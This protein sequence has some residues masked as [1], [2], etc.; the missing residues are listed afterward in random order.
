MNQRKHNRGAAIITIVMFF[1]IISV[2]VALGL[3]SPT[4]REYTSAR[5]FEKSK[6]AYYLSEA[7]NEDATYRIKNSKTI[8]MTETL[9]LGGNTAITTIT[10][11]GGQQDIVSVGN[12]NTHTRKVSAQLVTSSGVSFNYGVQAGA[13]GVFLGNSASITG[14]LFS[15]GPVCG[16][17]ATGATCSGGSGTNT[18]TG[19]IIS[20]GSGTNGVIGR[21]RNTTAGSAMYAGTISNSTIVGPAYCNTISGSSSSPSGCQTLSSQPPADMP[22]PDAQVLEWEAAAEAGGVATAVQCSGGKYVINSSVTLGPIKIPC[23]LEISSSGKVKL[24]GPVWVTT[25]LGG[26][27]NI[28]LKNNAEV[29]VD[30]ALG[31]SPS[32]AVS[33]AII[34]DPGVA[35]RATKGTISLENSVKFNQATGSNPDAH[36]LLLSWN[37]GASVGNG[38][39]AIEV[40]NSAQGNLLVY[41]GYGDIKLQNSVSLKEVTGYKI[42]L[43]NSA[44]VIYSAGLANTLFI[45]GPGGSWTINNWTESL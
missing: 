14:N 10:T 39:E 16:G 30:P 43:Q 20:A 33:V 31:G 44:N 5:D 2:V 1:V 27:A 45:S 24:A 40:E 6:G 9:V 36:V 26:N 18:V 29:N 3:A 23:D 34:A 17:G 25:G 35:T 13:G 8:D 37:T 28:S 7:G 42:T 4:V 22:I 15:I 21:L 12:I 11:S 41:A 38:T 19:T 32:A